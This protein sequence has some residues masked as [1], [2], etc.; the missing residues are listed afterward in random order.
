MVLI[1]PRSAFNQKK[2]RRN[3]YVDIKVKNLCNYELYCYLRGNTRWFWYNIEFIRLLAAW[4]ITKLKQQKRGELPH[5]ASTATYYKQRSERQAPTVEINNFPHVAYT[6]KVRGARM[7][8]G[9]GVIKVWQYNL[10]SGVLYFRLRN[11]SK[12]ICY[13]ICWQLKSSIGNLS[14]SVVRINNFNLLKNYQW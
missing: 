13:L 14:Y 4:N 9:K 8:R 3:I 10:K 5:L 7:G 1:Q 2:F 6:S 11:F 12:F